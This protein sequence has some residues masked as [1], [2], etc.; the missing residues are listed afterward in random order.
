MNAIYVYDVTIWC[1]Q[2]TREEVLGLFKEIAK[3]WAFQKEKCPT[4]GTDHFQCRISLHSK[5]RSNELVAKLNAMGWSGKYANLSPTS[6][7]ESTGFN[8]VMKTESRVEG[9]W[10]DKDPVPPY[11]PRQIREM[12][13]LKGWQLD[14]YRDIGVWE[15]RNINCIINHSG[16][17]GKTSLGGYLLAHGKGR[18][19]PPMSSYEDLMKLLLSMPESNFYMVDIPR[20]I[21]TKSKEKRGM[22]AA[23]EKLKDGHVWDNRYEWKERY[24]DCPNVWVFTNH[25]PDMTCLSP[26]RWIFWKIEDEA[27]WKTS[28]LVRFNPI[29]KSEEEA[30]KDRDR[31]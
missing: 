11:I 27:N 31:K 17:V 9:P 25:L 15:T 3:H 21:D 6:T 1:S 2:A 5:K 8:Y 19:V 7:H 14:V 28:R 29:F 23:I 26:D 4:T 16:N 24:F 10:T 20:A 30:N 12:G 13:E 18:M 22:Y